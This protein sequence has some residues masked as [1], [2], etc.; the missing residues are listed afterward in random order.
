M[1]SVAPL[2]AASILALLLLAPLAQAAPAA[3]V[4]ESTR[5][6]ADTTL[7]EAVLGEAHATLR[8]ARALTAT[9]RLDVM[10]AFSQPVVRGEDDHVAILWV[11]PADGAP[12]WDGAWWADSPMGATTPR[13]AHITDEGAFLVVEGGRHATGDRATV[14]FTFIGEDGAGWTYTLPA[15]PVLR[16]APT[17]DRASFGGA[18]A[19]RHGWDLPELV[20]A[21]P[22]N[23]LGRDVEMGVSIVDAEGR[24]TWESLV[25]ACADGSGR[26][27]EKGCRAT[28][29]LLAAPTDRVVVW[30][31]AQDGARVEGAAHG[32]DALH[33]K[34]SVH[35]ADA[36][37][38]PA[39][40]VSARLVARA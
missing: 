20:V 38:E 25:G 7:V 23:T 34:P 32:T 27:T 14:T 10:L 40:R 5:I 31:I 11:R 36:M 12:A 6:E 29:L 39:T 13:R 22:W 37:G 2:R 26:I 35:G 17:L 3:A 19:S 9:P 18:A 8:V 30:H 15:V 1:P 4:A 16:A 24:T 33:A 28:F 21:T